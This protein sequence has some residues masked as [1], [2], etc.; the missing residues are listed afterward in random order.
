VGGRDA[1]GRVVLEAREGGG[2][3][4]VFL[5]DAAEGLYRLV[6]FVKGEGENFA[7]DA[8][9]VPVGE[10]RRFEGKF[11]FDRS[12]IAG[13]GLVVENI[14][15]AAIVQAGSSFDGTGDIAV[16]LS[17]FVGAP[18]S[19]RVSLRFPQFTPK[20]DAA[21]EISEPIHIH[22]AAATI[23]NIVA[24][25]VPE[26]VYKEGV[27]DFI[28]THEQRPPNA[29]LKAF[30]ANNHPVDIFSD[31]KPHIKWYAAGLQE[32]QALNPGGETLCNHPFVVE[33][34]GQYRHALIGQ[35][36][37]GASFTHAVAIPDVLGTHTTSHEDFDA[38][39]LC[40]PNNQ[41]QGSP[42]YWIKYF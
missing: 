9:L 24:E 14:A 6:L 4:T 39:K 18:Y 36:E 5:Q 40:H 33:K 12:N 35:A 30:F 31:H 23:A 17:G 13:S 29:H 11:D 41:E 27:A 3:A 20:A 21:E 19:W 38:F 25:E 34:A 10:S 28:H 32:L 42:G 22:D 26:P 37:D 2:R 1:T 7:A 8:G 16:A 15:G